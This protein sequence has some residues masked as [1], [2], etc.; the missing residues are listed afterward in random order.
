MRE[1]PD[2]IFELVDNV[3]TEL[4][5]A[6]EESGDLSQPLESGLLDM[7]RVKLMHELLASSV[8]TEEL[9]EKTTYFKSVGMGLFDLCV[10]E[11]LVRDAT[12]KGNGQNIK[13]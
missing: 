2:V 3:Y 1:I 12:N 5:Y 10:A 11:R 4:E 9:A 7:D 13:A 8:D 6:C